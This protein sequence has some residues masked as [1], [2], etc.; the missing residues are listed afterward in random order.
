MGNYG[1]AAQR[2]RKIARL[3]FRGYT[4]EEIVEAT[5]ISTGQVAEDLRVIRFQLQPQTIQGLEYYRNKSR[6]RLDMIRKKAWELV[7]DRVLGESARIAALEVARKVE[8]LQT[9]VDGIV[10]GKM[11]EGPDKRAT[12]LQKQLLK[13]APQAGGD[14]HNKSS[15]EVVKDALTNTSPEAISS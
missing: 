12:E 8:D 6:A 2:Q 14:G 4:K 15:N 7:D 10:T 3:W 11:T 9:K 5:G 1:E 13:L